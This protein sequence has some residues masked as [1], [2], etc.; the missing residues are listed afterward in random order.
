MQNNYGVFFMYSRR[1]VARVPIASFGRVLPDGLIAFVVLPYNT[2]PHMMQEKKASTRFA[3]L[4]GLWRRLYPL[5]ALTC[6][7]VRAPMH[8]LITYLHLRCKKK[9]RKPRLRRI[10]QNLLWT[11]LSC[12]GATE[13]KRYARD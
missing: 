10:G 8:C 5:L 6:R 4:R 11:W 1:D 12:V 9:S 7:G 13:K 3:S 2:L